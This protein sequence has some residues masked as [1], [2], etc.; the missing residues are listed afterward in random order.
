VTDIAPND[1]A[2]LPA[3]A[4]A[5]DLLTAALSGRSGMEEGLNHPALARLD[6]RDR[7]FARALVL[8]TLRHLGPIDS[9]L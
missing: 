4:A 9:A 1:A 8:A 5:L 3:R 6:G 2:G 7:A